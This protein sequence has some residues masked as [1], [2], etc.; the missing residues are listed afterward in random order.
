MT[1]E[2]V[3]KIVDGP[4]W[5]F[6]ERPAPFVRGQ[7]SKLRTLC[8]RKCPLVRLG[9]ALHEA[10]HDVAASLRSRLLQ[11]NAV[12][13]C[14]GRWLFDE[15]I[16][17]RLEAVDC[18][19][20]LDSWMHRHDHPIKLFLFEHLAVI[21]VDVRDAKIART[22]LRPLFVN[23]AARDQVADSA[24]LG[25][26]ANRGAKNLRRVVHREPKARV[27]ILH[28][29]A[30]TTD[31]PDARQVRHRQEPSGLPRQDSSVKPTAGENSCDDLRGFRLVDGSPGGERLDWLQSRAY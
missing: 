3:Q 17:S 18:D 10:D 12:L 14:L 9:K 2:A 28:G 15:D 11:C 8:N 6:P 22:P 1:A 7:G 26:I 19:S 5:V 20:G 25:K 29:M 31:H 21:R 4:W 23:V 24:T 13:N 27:E 16:K 30:A